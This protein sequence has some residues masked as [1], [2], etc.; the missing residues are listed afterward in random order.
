MIT[1]GTRSGCCSTNLVSASV[2]MKIQENFYGAT[3]Q[4]SLLRGSLW[5]EDQKRKGYGL[6]QISGKKLAPKSWE[7]LVV[8]ESLG[9]EVE[10]YN[11]Q[12]QEN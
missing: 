12:R 2:D 4:E 3:M 1:D 5:V 7:L 6:Y 11:P 10:K 9:M 8:M